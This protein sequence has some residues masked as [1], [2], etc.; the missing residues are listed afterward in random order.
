MDLRDRQATYN[1][2]GDALARAFELVL[3]PAVFG[4]LGWLL[5]RWLG[6]TPLFTV[7]LTLL[8]FLYVGWRLWTGYETD[9]RAHE[10]RM[11]MDREAGTSA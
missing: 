8:V 7:G 10:R 6:V 1:G 4:F 2:F 9:M 11:G 5:D 3:T